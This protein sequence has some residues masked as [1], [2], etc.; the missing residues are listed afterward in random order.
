[1]GR[2]DESGTE[3]VARDFERQWRKRFERFADNEDDAGI[4]GWSENG[5]DARFSHFRNHWRPGAPGGFWLDV[6][7]GAGTYTRYMRENGKEV[8]ALDYS[9]PTLKKARARVG[10]GAHWAL[11]DASRLPLRRNSLDGVLC[12]GVTQALSESGPLVSELNRVVRG[13]GEVW[14]D[15]LNRGCALDFWARALRKMRGEEE[16]VRFESPRGLAEE[17]RRAGAERVELYWVPVFP[18]GW[19]RLQRFFNRY[20]VGR[21]LDRTPFLGALVCHAFVLKGEAPH[22]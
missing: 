10:G 14:V 6:G 17:L 3:P 19:H 18:S 1:M 15:G 2:T 13:G 7:C 4:A 8:L 11:G 20:W 5:L 9:L 21:V 12:F 22:G 16:N